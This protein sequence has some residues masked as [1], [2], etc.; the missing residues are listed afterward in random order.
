MKLWTVWQDYAATG[1]GRTLMAR[2]AHA[3]SAQ[4]ALAGFGLEFD[5]YFSVGAEVAE[6]V[7]QNAV[8][9]A[10]FAAAALRRL[11]Q[12]EGRATLE[13]AARFHFNVA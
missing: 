5:S 10:L 11:R 6:G 7:Q 13:L 12:M 9:Q 4:D 2:I 8:T 3:E 1:E